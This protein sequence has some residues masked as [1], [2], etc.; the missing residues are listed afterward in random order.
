MT[1]SLQ[2]WPNNWDIHILKYC[3]LYFCDKDIEYLD[4]DLWTETLTNRPH[5]LKVTSINIK[6]QIENYHYMVN[7]SNNENNFTCD[8]YYKTTLDTNSFN[9]NC[10]FIYCSEDISLLHAIAGIGGYNITVSQLM[11]FT[12][13]TILSDYKQRQSNDWDNEDEESN[14][15]EPFY[16]TEAI[17]PELILV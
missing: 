15:V 4:K 12:E 3:E 2:K 5:D 8:V 17:T 9:Q 10:I 13:Q 7:I 11:E 1:L 6:F 14:P 16:P